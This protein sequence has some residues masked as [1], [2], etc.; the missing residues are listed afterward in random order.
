MLP[1]TPCVIN[2]SGEVTVTGLWPVSPG[3]PTW[4]G[5]VHK[6]EQLSPSL[7]GALRTKS[8]ALAP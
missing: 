5:T 4:V 2:R 7:M 8:I 3:A 1:S 6:S